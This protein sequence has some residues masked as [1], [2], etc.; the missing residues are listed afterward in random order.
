[1]HASRELE[2]LLM[3][4]L[5]NDGNTIAHLAAEG[6][7]VAVFKVHGNCISTI[8]SKISLKVDTISYYTN[9]GYI[10]VV[11]TYRYSL[12]ED[13]YNLQKFIMSAG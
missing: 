7:H 6:G 1:M 3:S 12:T 5:D 8:Y 2:D 13:N 4:P 9:L 10:T 11:Y